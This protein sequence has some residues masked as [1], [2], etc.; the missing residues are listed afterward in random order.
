MMRKICIVGGGNI[1]TYLATSISLKENTD[2]CIYTNKVSSFKDTLTIIDEENE[3]IYTSRKVK[4][5]ND[6]EGAV[7][8]ADLILVTLPASVIGKVLYNISKCIKIGASIGIIPGFGGVEFYKELF[9]DKN[10]TFF[11]TQRVPVI[12]RLKKYGDTVYLKERNEFMRVAS[13]PQSSCKD[14]C[15]LLEEILDLKCESLD[16]YLSVT[17]SPSNPAMHPARLYELFR[18]YIPNETI[19]EKRELFYEEWKDNASEY[20][21]KIDEEI[22]CIY[23]SI[24][25]LNLNQKETIKCRFNVNNK[26]QLTDAIKNVSGF[27]NIYT[28]MIKMQ[29][30]YIPDLDSRYFTADIPYG[31]CILKAF[32]EIYNISTPMID[33]I[34]IWAQKILN[35]EYI[36]ENRLCGTNIN[37]LT[38][39]QN[40]NINTKK[41]LEE[42]YSK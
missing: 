14:I 20:L 13:F 7:G 39:P 21:L 10:C 30:G 8:D 37:E 9:K 31:L 25:I 12:A 36:K 15:T 32:A 1:G 2:V 33:E 41:C 17:L 40:Y 18:E 29:D 6:I 5:T 27:K 19:Y 26:Q 35:K 3:K 23:D 42:Y 24:N 38:I 4:I 11:G 16:N 28:D 34:I 22:Q